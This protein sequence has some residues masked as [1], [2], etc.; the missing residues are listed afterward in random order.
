MCVSESTSEVQGRR[1][2]KETKTGKVR[3]ITLPT[4]LLEELTAHLGEFARIDHVVLAFTRPDGG[5]IS[6]SNFRKRD[7]YP[8]CVRAEISPVPHLH[9]LRHTAALAAEAGAH[10]KLVQEMLGHASIRTTLDVYGNL[11]P[12]LNEGM[13]AALDGMR[14]NWETSTDVKGLSGPCSRSVR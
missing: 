8:A 6:A 3:S 13:S 14:R 5:P 4:F 10:P 1:V 9:A 11:F 12:S 7:F 2:V